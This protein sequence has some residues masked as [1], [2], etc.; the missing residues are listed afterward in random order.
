[1]GIWDWLF[2]SEDTTQAT[3]N[4][5]A[6]QAGTGSKTAVTGAAVAVMEGTDQVKTGASAEETA[7]PPWYM[8]EGATAVEPGPPIHRELTANVRAIENI[9]ISYF[10]GHDLSMPSLPQAGE[11]ALAELRRRNADFGKVAGA[12]SDDQVLAA[13][14]LR[15]VNSPLYRGNN[16]IE[17]LKA[18]VTRL[19]GQAIKSL[20]MH[21]AMRTAMFFEHGGDNEMAR[22][23]WCRSVASGTIMRGLARFVH[24]DEENAFLIGLLHDIGNVIVLRIVCDQEARFHE[25]I[26]VESFQ[27]LCQETHQEFGELVAQE[28]KL[29]EELRIL[30]ADHH[31]MPEQGDALA[32]QRWMVILTDM[33]LAQMGYDAQP[34]NY[35]LIRSKPV[36]ALHL[37]AHPRFTFFLDELP[38]DIEDALSAF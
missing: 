27:Y 10:D 26:D 2:G 20:I 13:S 17:S 19:G 25:R 30:I 18:A 23:I 37:A 31:T 6:K 34:A 14:V 35:D 7:G 1:M 29:P 28:W 12:I 15:V 21:H 4:A 33:M 38:E 5:G 3:S 8:P 24:I 11:A 9:L 32:T 36:E 22:Y 16:K